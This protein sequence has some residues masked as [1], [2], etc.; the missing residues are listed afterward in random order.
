M[1]IETGAATAGRVRGGEEPPTAT[2]PAAPTS[3][4]VWAASAQLARLV[5]DDEDAEDESHILRG[6]D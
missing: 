1:K 6:L 5:L 3:L 2:A 4:A